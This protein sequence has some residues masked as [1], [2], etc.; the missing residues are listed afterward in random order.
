MTN[1]RRWSAARAG[2]W[3]EARPWLCGFNYLPGTAVNST[4]M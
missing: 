2:A 1:G 3:A 4:A